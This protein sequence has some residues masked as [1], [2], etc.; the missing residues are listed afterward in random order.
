MGKKMMRVVNDHE[1]EIGPFLID[2]P[3]MHKLAAG[4]I[5]TLLCC[6]SIGAFAPLLVSS[7]PFRQQQIAAVSAPRRYLSQAHDRVCLRAGSSPTPDPPP[8]TKLDQLLRQQRAKEKEPQSPETKVDPVP[9]ASAESVEASDE[10]KMAARR[11]YEEK[12]AKDQE[13]KREQVE[14]EAAEQQ[15]KEAARE[16][17]RERLRIARQ[18]DAA[19]AQR[20]AEEK[21]AAEALRLKMAEE[22][23]AREKA[24]EE[25]KARLKAEQ[26]RRKLELEAAAKAAVQA[27]YARLE[28]CDVEGAQEQRA[29]AALCFAEGGI[30]EEGLKQ[31]DEAITIRQKIEE[32]KAA[33]EKMLAQGRAALVQARD[34]LAKDRPDIQIARQQRHVASGCFETYGVEEFAEGISALDNLIVS[35]EKKIASIEA[36]QAALRVGFLKVEE[37][38]I[39]GA[40]EQRA[41]AALSF[42]RY[43]V[44]EDGL[45]KLDAQIE[46]VRARNKAID[47]GR[48]AVDAGME[49]LAKISPDLDV[50]RQ[51][52]S[53]AAAFFEGIED[54]SLQNLD[55]EIAYAQEKMEAI[56]AGLAALQL[57]LSVMARNQSDTIEALEYRTKAVAS[58]ARF[59]VTEYDADISELDAA[60]AAR[61][62]KLAAISSGKSALEAARHM[63]DA[64][65]DVAGAE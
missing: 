9:D 26:E 43:D 63:L 53:A 38:D 37:N 18:I 49:E 40:L 39:N 15:K 33:R 12:A 32:E 51:H 11:Y 31:L 27:A 10:A 30:V 29:Q 54:A 50:A 21:A 59:G 1:T 6:S 62:R 47:Q 23:A 52:R 35:A 55:D 60:I 58:F 2:S 56:E 19:A 34:E 14:R 61:Q 5:C 57:G 46:A 36:G 45:E 13:A 42:A 7:R 48:T 28:D 4:C 8:E 25:E 65:E 20:R 64:N 44:V 41:K 24:E 22:E 16:A 3:V 17:A